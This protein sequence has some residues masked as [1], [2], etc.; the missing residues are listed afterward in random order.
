MDQLF[1]KHHIDP[2][3]I[4]RIEVGT[5][6]IVDKSKSVKS[7]LMDYMKSFGNHDVEGIMSVHAC[8]GGTA[9][10][11]NTIAWMQSEAWDGRLGLVVM[12]DIAV[13]EDGSSRSTAGSGAVALLISPDAPLV[14]EP[15]RST[16]MI[17]EYDFYKPFMN[18]EYPV[19]NG[20]TSV[21]TYISCLVNCYKLLKSKYKSI[22]KSSISLKDFDQV[23]F[24][25]PFFKQVKKSFFNLCHQDMYDC[26]M[27]QTRQQHDVRQHSS[28]QPEER[29][30]SRKQR[31]QDPRRPFSQTFQREVRVRHHILSRDRQHLHGFS[32]PWSCVLPVPQQYL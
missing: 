1:S 12:S 28:G 2:I 23:V 10:L 11:F 13:Y 25:A 7:Y 9:A 4:G 20:Q 6:T 19:V 29:G 17:H 14:M 3:N 16:H 5:E 22:D 21:K 15:I 24:H 26:V 27:K 18:S 32:L 30:Y 8:Y 31:L